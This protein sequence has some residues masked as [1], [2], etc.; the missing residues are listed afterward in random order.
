MSEARTAEVG[1][2]AR[3]E[4]RSSGAGRVV[5]GGRGGGRSRTRRASRAARATAR[6]ADAIPL[7]FGDCWYRRVP[8]AAVGPRPEPQQGHASPSSGGSCAFREVFLDCSHRLSQIFGQ[9]TEGGPQEQTAKRGA[10]GRGGW[11]LG[12]HLHRGGAGSSR[13]AGAWLTR[14]PRRPFSSPL[15]PGVPPTS[16]QCFPAQI[17]TRFPTGP[18]YRPV[19]G[20]SLVLDCPASQNLINVCRELAICQAL[21]DILSQR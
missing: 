10:L 7:D 15:R 20:P 16:S 2:T 5:T 14:G 19:F 11:V 6:C 9:D 21:C 8:F 12:L 4:P 1:A 17:C 18:S 3:R 13:R